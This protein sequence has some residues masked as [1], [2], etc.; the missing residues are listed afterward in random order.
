MRLLIEVTIHHYQVTLIVEHVKEWRRVI[1]SFIR[2]TS[3]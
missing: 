1:F 3:Y 2:F